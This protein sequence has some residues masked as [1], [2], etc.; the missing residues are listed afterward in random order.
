MYTK[1]FGLKQRPFVLTPDPEFLYLSKVHD[2]AI[3]H[4]EYGI[5]QNVGFLALTGDVGAG[6]TTLLKYLFEKIKDS[7]D[8]AM[9]FNTNLDPHAFLEMLVKEFELKPRS[10]AKSDLFDSLAQHFIQQYSKGNRCVII[11]DEAQN[12]PDE[13]FEE[14]RMLSNLEAGNE[15]IVQIILVGQP[16]LRDRLLHPALAQLAQRISVHYHLTP[17]P[18][19]EVKDYIE[20]RLKV[21][22]YLGKAPLFDENAVEHIAAVS[23]GVPRIINSVC[24]ACLTYAYADDTKCINKAIVEKVIEDNELLQAFIRPKSADSQHKQTQ[25][26]PVA[27]QPNELQAIRD[28]L[29][30]LAGKVEALDKR[31]DALESGKNDK[32][33]AILEGLLAKERQRNIILEKRLISMG[34]KLKA[35]QRQLGTVDSIERDEN[36]HANKKKGKYWRLFGEKILKK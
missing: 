26:S 9:L 22:G 32:V 14:L 3:T 31:I 29:V 25:T 13:T 10:S 28:T 27:L 4:L 34:E 7:L 2:L 1:F 30:K 20:H 35:L 16:Q 18:Q 6:K 24:D 23:K 19:N 8:I 15:F 21:A 36:N 12:L 33:V 5:V 11:V 17:L